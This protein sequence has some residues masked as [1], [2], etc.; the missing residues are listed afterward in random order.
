ML[1][2][3]FED[4]FEPA[5]E[6]EISLRQKGKYEYHIYLGDKFGASFHDKELAIELAT[7]LGKQPI[8][9]VYE[10]PMSQEGVVGKIIWASNKVAEDIFKPATNQDIDNRRGEL[11]K[12]N[13]SA[14]VI[15]SIEKELKKNG[16]MTYSELGVEETSSFIGIFYKQE[17]VA[18]IYVERTYKDKGYRV[19][20]SWRKPA[21]DTYASSRGAKSNRTERIVFDHLPTANE[22]M[23]KVME[24]VRKGITNLGLK[25]SL[26]SGEEDDIF[27]PASKKD[28][29]GRQSEFLS[30]YPAYQYA[31]KVAQALAG[32]GYDATTLSA[33]GFGPKE[34]FITVRRYNVKKGGGYIN[35]VVHSVTEDLGYIQIY[36]QDETERWVV[37]YKRANDLKTKIIKLYAGQEAPPVSEIVKGFELNLK[38]KITE[39]IFKAA[40]TKDIDDRKQDQIKHNMFKL[41]ERIKKAKEVLPRLTSSLDIADMGQRMM[42]RQI[43]GDIAYWLKRYIKENEELLQ[44]DEGTYKIK[45]MKGVYNQL[46]ELGNTQLKDRIL[47][48]ENFIKNPTLKEDIFKPADHQDILNRREQEKQELEKEKAEYEQRYPK[49]SKIVLKVQGSD[50]KAFDFPERFGTIGFWFVGKPSYEDT[51]QRIYMDVTWDEAPM[52]AGI[53]PTRQTSIQLD[54]V[55]WYLETKQMTITPPIQEDIFKPAKRQDL[56]KR[57][58]EMVKKLGD[59]VQFK[60]ITDQTEIAEMPYNFGSEVKEIIEVGIDYVQGVLAVYP[61]HIATSMDDGS[62]AQTFYDMDKAKE[63]AKAHVIHQALEQPG[64]LDEDIFKPV[65]P[66]D[67][68]NRLE[69]TIEKE[70]E[71]FKTG[72]VKCRHCYKNK[73]PGTLHL[74]GN[75]QWPSV[76]CDKCKGQY[77]Y[78]WGDLYIYGPLRED[79]FKPA[80]TEELGNRIDTL[81]KEMVNKITFE[82]IGQI[83]DSPGSIWHRKETGKAD[84][85]WMVKLEGHTVGG[86]Y[87]YKTGDFYLFPVPPA[88]Q[89]EWHKVDILTFPKFKTFEEV[90]KFAIDYVSEKGAKGG[91][92]FQL[93]EDIF[94]PATQWELQSREEA[95][96]KELR[97]RLSF[98]KMQPNKQ[99]WPDAVESWDILLNREYMGVILKDKSGKFLVPKSDTPDRRYVRPYPYTFDTL[100]QAQDFAAEHIEDT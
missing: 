49:G 34:S 33:E 39:D 21:K 46:L 98:I 58:M 35:P 59:K 5:S 67:R 16:Y 17:N 56:H 52:A 63:Y 10:F 78:E 3:V 7:S 18:S 15:H 90:S 37:Y 68:H 76:V 9:R 65:D 57:R 20:F 77:D 38:D 2:S 66:Q 31:E 84:K 72:K 32:A 45:D 1:K 22:L 43:Q 48:A 80:G 81:K 29:T 85:G 64:Y 91:Y 25:E 8:V 75:D 62:V 99:T 40:T 42:A 47:A 86:I 13:P 53:P 93:Y 79:I 23:P 94:K 97:E 12:T 92:G 89:T 74:I 19:E 88:G 55:K 41:S 36:I 6:E 28:I 27:K 69:Q 44:K 24:T 54:N 87:Y 4:I 61:T 51:G 73:K 82:E 83:A 11:A 96:L 100:R 70:K 30:M 50:Q 26:S 14:G 95:R 60:P 71:I